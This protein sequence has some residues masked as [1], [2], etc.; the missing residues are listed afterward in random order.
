MGACAESSERLRSPDLEAFQRFLVQYHGR[1]PKARAEDYYKLIHQSVFGVGHLIEDEASARSS[2]EREIL[3][4]GPPKPAETLLE[5]LDPEGRMMRVNLRPF[6]AQKLSQDALMAV[7]LET[8]RTV[9]PDTSLFLGR[10]HAFGELVDRGE[11]DVPVE[12]WKEVDRFAR[13]RSYPP[14]HHSNDYRGAYKP[15][16]RVVLKGLFTKKVPSNY[17]TR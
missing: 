1:Y 13:E 4:L 7:L 12:D 5:P 6:V 17:R 2:L 3:T 14:V 8:A 9:E 15:A 16:Y 10:W 11:L